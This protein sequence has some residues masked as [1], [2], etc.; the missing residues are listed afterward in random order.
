MNSLTKMMTG[1]LDK[2]EKRKI[3]IDDMVNSQVISSE[4]IGELETAEDEFQYE[5]KRVEAEIRKM[6]KKNLE[7]KKK[8]FMDKAVDYFSHAK[9][10]LE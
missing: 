5:I 9:E 1:L 3:E 6:A 8:S 7:P 10:M 2:N 4:L